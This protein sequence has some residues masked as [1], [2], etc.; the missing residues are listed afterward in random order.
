MDRS[1][2]YINRRDG[3]FEEVGYAAGLNDYDIFCQGA[4]VADYNGDGILDIFMAATD[5]IM[6]TSGVGA[7]NRLYLSIDMSGSFTHGGQTIRFPVFGDSTASAGIPQETVHHFAPTAGDFDQDGDMDIYVCLRSPHVDP[8]DTTATPNQLLVNDLVPGGKAV[9]T[10]Q[11]A[12][13][14]VDDGGNG[15]GTCFGDY[16]NDGDLDL[17]VANNAH[18]G[19][20]VPDFKKTNRLFRNEYP[21]AMFVEETVA[22]FSQTFAQHNNNGAF[23]FDFDLDTDQDFFIAQEDTDD[24]LGDMVFRQDNGVFSEQTYAEGVT[25]SCD[26]LRRVPLGAN[27][28]YADF[29][30][31]GDLDLFV[32]SSGSG[33]GCTGEGVRVY[34]NRT[35]VGGAGNNYL[36]V[37]LHGR[38]AGPYAAHRDAIGSVARVHVGSTVLIQQV[39]AGAQDGSTFPFDLTFGLGAA[40]RVDSVVVTWLNTGADPAPTYTETFLGPFVANQRL[41]LYLGNTISVPKDLLEIDDAI[42]RAVTGTR[43]EVSKNGPGNDPYASFIMKRG[44]QVVAVDTTVTPRVDGTN[45]GNAVLFPTDSDSLTILEG[46]QLQAVSGNTATLLLQGSGQVKN[47]TIQDNGVSMSA[48]VVIAGGGTLSDCTVVTTGSD[49]SIQG[50]GDLTITGCTVDGGSGIGVDLILDPDAVIQNSIVVNAGTYSVRGGNVSYCIVPNGLDSPVTTV[51]NVVEAPYFCPGSYTLCVDSYG[52]PMNNP[53]QQLIGAYP[54]TCLYGDLARD[55]RFG[56]GSLTVLGDVQIATSLTLTLDANTVLTVDTTNVEMPGLPI[57]FVVNGILRATGTQAAP[58]R[59]EAIDGAPGSWEGIIPDFAAA[60]V[61]LKYVEIRHA[62]RA[63]GSFNG[64]VPASDVPVDSLV[65]ENV[66]IE[67]VS[68]YGVFA[69]HLA[70]GDGTEVLVFDDVTVHAAGATGA[71]VWIGRKNLSTGDENAGTLPGYRV[72][73][74]DVTVTGDGSADQGMYLNDEGGSSTDAI[75]LRGQVSGFSAGAGIEVGNLSPSLQA[76][77]MGPLVN[78]CKVGIELHGSGSPVIQGSGP[79][80]TTIENATTGLEAWDS[81]TPTVTDVAINCTPTGTG[82]YTAGTSGG[83]YKDVDISGGTYGFKAYSTAAHTFREGSI[84]GWSTN[85]VTVSVAG[86]PD[87][88]TAYSAGQNNIHSSSGSGKPV[89]AKTRLASLGDVT[90]ENNYWGVVPPPTMRNVDAFPYL[91]SSSSYSLPVGDIAPVP[92]V[93]EMRLSPNPFPAD[94]HGVIRLAVPPEEGAYR[95]DLHDVQGRHLLRVA[96][97]DAGANGTTREVA[98]TGRGEGGRALPAGMYFLRLQTE[99]STRVVKIVRL[100]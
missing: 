58:V 59:F 41:N 16:D 13:Y 31:D 62:R 52:N 34:E 68:E 73:I 57:E 85:G 78:D 96:E 27:S 63:I 95:V 33:Y 43:I 26:S 66:T 67:N 92:E 82:L 14:G 49:N 69:N 17:L 65:L 91:S 77:S 4:A 90:A 40:T 37:R 6:A 75:V 39:N 87:L 35:R 56:G 55:S 71:G 83:A 8:P 86:L 97:G 23:F 99:R 84:L 45:G 54:V 38:D 7:P 50:E 20:T 46:V 48:N 72:R 42:K 60:R 28:T 3:T 61:L 100:P 22:D 80:V 93:L 12:S 5:S 64:Y 19:E 74:E 32:T 11:A 89:K 53:S 21:A 70:A 44:T 51:G 94:G 81:V 76:G 1:L 47:C 9:F 24:D 98:W 30:A 15:Y 29:D 10:D 25:Q 88:G 79:A 18:P 2:L 36:T